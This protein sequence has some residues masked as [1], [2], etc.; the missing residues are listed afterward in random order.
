MDDLSRCGLIPPPKPPSP[1]KT[2]P[3]SQACPGLGLPSQARTA[4]QRKVRLAETD[5]P[6]WARPL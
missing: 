4:A 5:L 2:L 3:Q 1:S 6:R